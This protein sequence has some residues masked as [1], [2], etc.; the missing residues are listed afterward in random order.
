[1]KFIPAIDL[2]NNKVVTAIKGSQREYQ[3]ISSKLSP[4]S[5][6]LKFI[7][8]ILSFNN[9]ST[10]YLADLDSIEEFKKYNSVVKI[11]LQEYENI[12]FIIDNGARKFSQLNIYKNN[13]FKQIIATESFED[14]ETIIKK[15]FHNYILSVDIANDK[16]LHKNEKYKYLKPSKVISMNIDSVGRKNGINEKNISYIRQIFPHS[17]IIISGGIGCNEDVNRAIGNGSK[18]IILLTAILE[19]KINLI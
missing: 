16:I 18:E 2:K 3:E 4:T 10:I 19:K 5:D 13:N 1:M 15:N 17:D 6:P 11:I 7:E 8:F 12:S 14:Y 9:F